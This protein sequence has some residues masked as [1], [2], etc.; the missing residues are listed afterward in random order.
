M[1]TSVAGWYFSFQGTA[2]GDG[3]GAM[4]RDIWE[5]AGDRLSRDAYVSEKW[6]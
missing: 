3:D 1:L 5:Q 4:D 2:E 6:W